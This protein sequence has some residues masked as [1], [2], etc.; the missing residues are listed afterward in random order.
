MN[1]PTTSSSERPRRMYA[2]ERYLRADHLMKAGKFISV[3][4]KIQDVVHGLPAKIMGGGE[5]DE[6]DDKKGI[7]LMPGL[8]FE[9]R[10]KLL[11]LNITNEALVCWETGE[12]NWPGW[13]GKEVQLVVR[14]TRAWN[15]QKKAWEDIPCIRVWPRV[16][17][18]SGR[19]RD[20]MG[21]EVTEEWYREFRGGYLEGQK[22]IE[23]P[24]K[25]APKEPVNEPPVFT[26][27]ERTRWIAIMETCISGAKNM[28]DIDQCRIR[29]TDLGKA[30]AEK[31]MPLTLDERKVLSDLLVAKAKSVVS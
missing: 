20:Q 30:L 12:G 14:L 28:A 8:L 17:H 19:V 11:G 27:E 4:V 24:V 9:G 13:I 26:V 18:S 10:E 3:K 15:K 7:K 2:G 16:A 1:Q 6:K 31:D 21:K 25:E 23:E 29:F 22:K 5:N